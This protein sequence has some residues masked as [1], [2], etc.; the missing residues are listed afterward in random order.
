MHF[1]PAG[2][3]VINYS[4]MYN[5]QP[6]VK[7]LCNIDTK[8]KEMNAKRCSGCTVAVRCQSVILAAQKHTTSGPLSLADA[9]PPW[10]AYFWLLKIIT[11]LRRTPFVLAFWSASEALNL[12][13]DWCDILSKITQSWFHLM[14]CGRRFLLVFFFFLSLEFD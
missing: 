5:K 9:K 2:E 1:H 6:L 8:H 3:S 11:H 4:I 12:G 13:G 7:A 10:W 14:K